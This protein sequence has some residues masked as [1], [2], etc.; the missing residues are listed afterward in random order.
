M[1]DNA[2]ADGKPYSGARDLIAMQTPEKP[3]DPFRM[4]RI[5]PDAVVLHGKDPLRL[6]LF[7]AEMNARRL[8]SPVLQRVADQVL[9]HLHQ[10]GPRQEY[11]W[12]PDSGYYGARLFQA[13]LQID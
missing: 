7:G 5:N 10:L 11:S 9:E 1:F 8:L 6:S 13:R 4:W 12:Q 2:L 3:E